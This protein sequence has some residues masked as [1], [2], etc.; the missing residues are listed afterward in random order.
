[1]ARF[2]PTPVSSLAGSTVRRRADVVPEPSVCA[3]S[4]GYVAASSL[5]IWHNLFGADL[6]PRGD[7]S[8]FVEAI[9]SIGSTADQRVCS[10]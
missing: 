6:S 10:G 3:P 7:V 9:V 8:G 4:V 2:E 5:R 1:L